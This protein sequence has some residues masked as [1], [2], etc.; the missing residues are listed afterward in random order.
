MIDPIAGLTLVIAQSPE[1]ARAQGPL[2]QQMAIANAQAPAAAAQL[3]RAA[4]D[5]TSVQPAL[6]PQPVSGSRPD[7]HSRWAYSRQRSKTG[8]AGSNGAGAADEMA[9]G[10]VIDMAA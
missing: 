9:L 6:R 1:A 5:V 2:L 7:P 8:T 3:A 4:E 10:S